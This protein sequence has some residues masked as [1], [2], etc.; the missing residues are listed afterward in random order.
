M[1]ELHLRH[2]DY[3]SDKL[4]D[5]RIGGLDAKNDVGLCRRLGI[6]PPVIS[7]IRHRHLRIDPVLLTSRCEESRLGIKELRLLMGSRRDRFRPAPSADHC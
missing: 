7:Q 1:T 4:L 6:L 3:D 5:A 2:P